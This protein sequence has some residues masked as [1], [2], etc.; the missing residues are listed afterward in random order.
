MIRAMGAGCVRV[1][2]VAVLGAGALFYAPDQAQAQAPASTSGQSLQQ[3]YDAAFAAMLS[4]PANLDKTFAYAA[5]AAQVGDLEGAVSALER[6]LL[7]DPNLPRVQLELG[8]LYYRL[9]SYGAARSYLQSA[10]QAPNMPPEVRERAERFM[11]EIEKQRSPSKFS[12]TVLA[13]IR[14]QSNANAAPTGSVKVGGFDAELDGNSTGQSDWNVFVAAN[15]LHIYDFGTQNGETWETRG[16]AYA[17]RQF[18]LHEVDAGIVTLTS[19]PRLP[20]LPAQI[21]GLTVRVAG[22]LDVVALDDRLDYV[23]PG[24]TVNLDKR[25]ESANLGFTFDW[26]RRDYN[27]SRDKPFNSDRDGYELAGRA[28]LEHQ[29]TSWLMAS[30]GVGFTHYDARR[31]YESYNEVQFYGQLTAML[32]FSPFVPEQHTVLSLAGARMISRYN[33]PDPAID[34]NKKRRDRDLRLSL[35]GSVPLTESIS[36]VVQGGYNRRDSSLPNYEYSNW[37]SMTGLAWRF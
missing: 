10:L 33:D 18:D 12:G 5:L 22:A 20:V 19:G 16:T 1:L 6:M 7:I 14:Y 35:T 27:D 30:A 21:K 28:V 8:V 2:A 25:F 4:D 17:A 13:G 31:E 24:A 29:L 11:A 23:A 37:F 15:A 9:G 34:P 36:L 32:P 26:R 3:Q